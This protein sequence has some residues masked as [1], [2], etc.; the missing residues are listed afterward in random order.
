[1]TA[2]LPVYSHG[3]VETFRNHEF[4]FEKE[5]HMKRFFVYHS[6]DTGSSKSMWFIDDL[7]SSFHAL[8]KLV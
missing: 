8:R 3:H 4:D 2:L 5:M 1:M 6:R 7:V